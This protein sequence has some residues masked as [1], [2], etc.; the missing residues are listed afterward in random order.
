MV[1]IETAKE[2]IE[3]L[4][5]YRNKELGFVPTMGA[6]HNGHLSL[7]D[8]SLQANEITVCSIFVNP[9][10]FNDTSDFDKYPRNFDKDIALLAERGCDVL[11]LPTLESMYQRESLLSFSFGALECVMEG[12]HRAGHFNGVAL[13]VSKLFNI[14]KP[15][16]VYFGQKD[17]QQC[18]IIQSLIK[19]LSYDI[20]FNMCP[21]IREGNGLAMSSRNQRLSE[22]E[23]EEAK[24]LFASLE[25]TKTNLLSGKSIK[26]AVDLS[27]EYLKNNISFELEYLEVANAETLQEIDSIEQGQEYAICIAGFLGRVRLIDNIVFVG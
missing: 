13:I 3:Y 7:I 17:L 6:L 10:Q 2:L 27:K 14:I 21:I 4:K 11:F 1:I 15:S 26:E 12:A 16:R 24:A 22:S 25:L 8:A 20:E 18:A 23:K 19:D 9:T 5:I